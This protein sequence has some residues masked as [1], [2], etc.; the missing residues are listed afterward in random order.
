MQ[1]KVMDLSGSLDTV[2]FHWFYY[3]L[4]DLS[5]DIDIFLYQSEGDANRHHLLRSSYFYYIPILEE[6]AV[7][8]D[9]R[10]N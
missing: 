10:C 7:P 2:R 5:K 6:Q 3:L 1:I 9:Y 4:R 8:K